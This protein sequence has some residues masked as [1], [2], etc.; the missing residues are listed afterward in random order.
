MAPGDCRCGARMIAELQLDRARMR[1][2]PVAAGPVL[3]GRVVACDGGLIEVA[4]LPLPIGSLGLIENDTG[5][6]CLAEVIGFRAGH[7]LMMLLGDPVLLRPGAK[8]CPEGR[9]GMVPV[10]EAFLGRAVDGEGN[11]W[12]GNWTC[13]GLGYLDRAT[14]RDAVHTA[15]NSSGVTNWDAVRIDMGQRGMQQFPHPHSS[16]G[17]GVAVDGDGVVW[18]AS[19]SQQRLIAFDPDLPAPPERVNERSACLTGC[20]AQHAAGSSQRAT[21]EAYCPQAF[22][23][24]FIASYPTCGGPIGV[25]V[26]QEGDTWVS[27]GS[28]IAMAFDDNGD[29]LFQS[30]TGRGSYSYSD[31]T[32]FQ[33][34]MFTAPQAR[35][36][37]VF[38]CSEDVE[39][40]TDDGQC[41]ID[42]FRWEADIRS[43]ER[44]V[45]K[46]CPM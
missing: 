13:G 35:W 40:L 22:D 37:Q 26:S 36:S 7:S 25:G 5:A 31:M 20:A 3:T 24:Q 34:R 38:D 42:F 9:P 16:H 43:E 10:G 44:R 32:G 28:M 18:F 14:W 6:D 1:A 46:E 19:S 11:V 4:G 12:W 39:H 2:A 23:G 8:V 41:L 15:T 30:P 45:G 33:L 21:C 27:C 17:R 29:V